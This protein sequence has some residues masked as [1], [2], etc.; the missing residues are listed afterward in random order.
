MLFISYR[1][2]DA[3]A[4][5]GRLH[6][7]LVKRY[8]AWNVFRDQETLRGGRPWPAALR[9]SLEHSCAVLAVVGR[10]WDSPRLDDPDDW[11]RQ[12]VEAGLAQGKLFPLLVD[13]AV[14][15]APR[16]PSGC[17]LNA[18]VQLQGWPLR[19]SLDFYADVDR[20][21]G[22]LEVRSP[23][24]AEIARRRREGQGLVRQLGNAADLGRRSVRL[25]GRVQIRSAANDLRD[26]Y[27]LSTETVGPTTIRATTGESVTVAAGAQRD[28]YLTLLIV[29]P[30]GGL[31]VRPMAD[32][33]TPGGDRPAKTFA[34]TEPAGV[35]EFAVVWTDTELPATGTAWTRFLEEIGDPVRGVREI[36]TPPPVAAVLR[37]RVEHEPLEGTP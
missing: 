35:E 25:D 15:P 14:M 33:L 4:A 24:L 12:E 3:N 2:E 7:H 34:L 26:R 10:T 22:E 16:W 8:G 32:G 23:P 11:V 17:P 20:I 28:G 13:G 27:D 1:V 36:E 18:V 31:A 37:F 19:N 6:D 30:D 29:S 21:C 9:Q 5:S